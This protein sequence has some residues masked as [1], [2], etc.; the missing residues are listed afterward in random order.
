[1]LSAMAAWSRGEER[2]LRALERH[3]EGRGALTNLADVIEFAPAGGRVA[4]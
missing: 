4:A 3:L 2:G 1:M